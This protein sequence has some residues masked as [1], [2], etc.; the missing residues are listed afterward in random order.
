[1]CWFPSG[2]SPKKFKDHQGLTDEVAPASSFG[3]F[4]PNQ[5]CLGKGEAQHLTDHPRLPLG[6]WVSSPLTTPAP[7]P[8]PLSLPASRLQ[9]SGLLKSEKLTSQHVFPFDFANAVLYHPPSLPV[10]IRFS[11]FI[12]HSCPVLS[13]LLILSWPLAPCLN[14]VFMVFLPEASLSLACG[15][16]VPLGLSLI[17]ALE[18]MSPFHTLLPLTLG[19]AVSR[20]PF[21]PVQSKILSVRAHTRPALPLSTLPHTRAPPKVPQEAH[22]HGTLL[23]RDPAKELPPG[24]MKAVSRHSREQELDFQGT[25]MAWLVLCTRPQV[26]PVNSIK[27]SIK[28][29]QPGVLGEMDSRPP[30]AKMEPSGPDVGSS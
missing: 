23:M 2:L 3:P 1:M 25:T 9:D 4:P 5:A 16:G 27:L 10:S 21:R 30:P 17:S 22:R 15:F 12:P 11:S 6:A 7:F 24:A 14:T 18:S 19:T 13:L 8:H 20:S 28:A 26:Y 29:D